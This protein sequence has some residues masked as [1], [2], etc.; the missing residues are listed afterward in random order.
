MD[1]T[2]GVLGRFDADHL[3]AALVGRVLRAEL[4][5]RL[6]DVEIR[7][8]APYGWE[9]PSRLDGGEP[10]EPLGEWSFSRAAEVAERI[11]LAIVIPVDSEASADGD[12]RRR[13]LEPG[14]LDEADLAV[15]YVPADPHLGLLARELIAQPVL[16]K[17]LAFMRLMGWWPAPS[18]D[19]TIREVDNRLVVVSEGGEQPLPSE[20]G[21]EDILAAVAGATV[22]DLHSPVLTAIRA[23]YEGADAGERARLDLWFDGVLAALEKATSPRAEERARA[24]QARISELE[25]R[26]AAVERAYEVRGQRLVEER[27]VFADHVDTLQR[28]FGA[29]HAEIA[30]ARA[31]A[32]RDAARAELETALRRRA[33]ELRAAADI[34]LASIKASRLWRWTRIPRAVGRRIRPRRQ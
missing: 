32:D 30:E 5:R 24:A 12:P 26:L 28:E 19:V 11:D 18:V 8:Y 25:A 13:W 34:E 3:E 1:L 21:F 20:I 2:I 15:E 23:S 4:R 22:A 7:F 6:P 29:T 31:R 33:D 14:A 10:A 17:R 16:E 9:R 27:L